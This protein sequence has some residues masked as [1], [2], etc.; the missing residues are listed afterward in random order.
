MRA[1]VLAAAAAAALVGCSP[2]RLS[3]QVESFRNSIVDLRVAL[4]AGIAELRADLVAQRSTVAAAARGPINIP[5]QCGTS[6]LKDSRGRRFPPCIATAQ[7]DNEPI[8][9]AAFELAPEKRRQ[10][11]ALVQYA[12]GLAAV[13]DARDSQALA[14]ATDALAGA[15]LVLA[16][17][18]GMPQAAAVPVVVGAVGT[19]A[20]IALDAERMAVLRRTV[21]RVDG[22]VATVAIGLG[23]YLTAVQNERLRI[24]NL[25]DRFRGDEV[26]RRA[27]P[28]AG[29]A[30]RIAV[31]Q[32]RLA[33]A[34]ALREADPKGTADAI[35]DAHA[36]LAA[37]AEDPAANAA[38]FAAA[39]SELA[40]QARGLR[41]GFAAKPRPGA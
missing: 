32:E 10:M 39:V 40:E 33:V 7:A 26:A 36:K 5:P 25:D 19:M 28:A 18:T 29:R 21:S 4:D 3:P 20:R 2:Y 12:G 27:E 41:A 17:S 13:T 11:A 6:Q 9:P 37:A 16:V 35:R 15:A 24:R 14:D 22:A 34:D 23:T 31:I 38:S 30:A 1:L 8:N